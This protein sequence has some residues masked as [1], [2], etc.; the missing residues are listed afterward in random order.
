MHKL[1]WEMWVVGGGW[2]VVGGGWSLGVRI[3]P[4]PP[5]NGDFWMLYPSVRLASQNLPLGA[6]WG[7]SCVLFWPNWLPLLSD[8]LYLPVFLPFSIFLL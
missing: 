3:P 4:P 1:H 5:Q 6:N 8:E 7:V 2:W